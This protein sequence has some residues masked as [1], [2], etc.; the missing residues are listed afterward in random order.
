[1][2]ERTDADALSNRGFGRRVSA[3]LC[4]KLSR[5]EQGTQ[6][7]FDHLAAADRDAC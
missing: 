1:M 3:N 5:I 4:D 6:L 7:A 2:P